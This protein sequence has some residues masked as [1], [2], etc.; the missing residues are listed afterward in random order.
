MGKGPQLCFAC[1][2]LL[3][4]DRPAVMD[5]DVHIYAGPARS[6]RNSLNEA[7][8]GSRWNDAAQVET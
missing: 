2:P 7:D 6:D 1:I 4:M 3:A 8:T 5:M